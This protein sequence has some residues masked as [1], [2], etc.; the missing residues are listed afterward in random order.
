MSLT[1]SGRHGLEGRVVRLRV[2]KYKESLART[3]AEN[4][5]KAFFAA[6]EPSAGF[7]PPP[8]NVIFLSEKVKE[9][10]A[11]KAK[12]RATVINPML[13]NSPTFPVNRSNANF[14]ERNFPRVAR[15]ATTLWNKG[16]LHPAWGKLLGI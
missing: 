10:E 3:D 9:R 15:F 14:F 4:E 8:D 11:E 13:Q 16:K 5:I 12:I 7:Y 6:G 2:K 1:E